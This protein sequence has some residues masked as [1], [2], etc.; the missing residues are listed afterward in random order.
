MLYFE[1]LQDY[2]YYNEFITYFSEK[3]R[4]ADRSLINWSDIQ[5][6]SSRTEIIDEKINPVYLFLKNKV[7]NNMKRWLT[8]M[9]DFSNNLVLLKEARI[10]NFF[11][12]EE[13]EWELKTKIQEVYLP[14]EYLFF[15]IFNTILLNTK[16]NM[17]TNLKPLAGEIHDHREET[18]I[19]LNSNFIKNIYNPLR[20][21]NL[22]FHSIDYNNY[23]IYNYVN[24][25]NSLSPAI[26]NMNLLEDDN[27]IIKTAVRVEILYTIYSLTSLLTISLLYFKFKKTIK[28]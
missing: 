2:T 16:V 8:I 25:Y 26:A 28:N 5:G 15:K 10:I 13:N 18:R 3:I 14:E 27:R 9:Q 1:A 20:H 17:L 19:I 11:V 6:F 22:M 24:R 23:L 21:I 7:D 12:I 4:S